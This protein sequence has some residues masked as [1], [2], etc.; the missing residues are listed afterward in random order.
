MNHNR[1]MIWAGVHQLINTWK[2]SPAI[3]GMVGLSKEKSLKAS[4]AFC[5]P[6]LHRLVLDFLQ[7]GFE[8]LWIQWQIRGLILS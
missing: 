8:Q 5:E 6:V 7:T 1:I 2:R 4:D 3:E